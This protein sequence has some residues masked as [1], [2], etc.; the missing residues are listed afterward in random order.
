MN[1]ATSQKEPAEARG[2]EQVIE[3]WLGDRRRLSRKTLEDLVSLARNSGGELVDVTPDDWCGTMWFKPWPR[4]KGAQLIENLVARGYV[5]EVFPLGIPHPEAV[6][7]L[8]R[9]RTFR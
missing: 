2:S 6:Q 7:V 1:E 3:R 5:V 4:P 9:N 8:V